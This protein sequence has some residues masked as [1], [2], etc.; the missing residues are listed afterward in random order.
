MMK[1]VLCVEKYWEFVRTLRN[2]ERV[3]DGFIE[4]INIT[5]E[6]QKVYM[7]KYSEYYRIALVNDIPAGYVGVIEDDIRICTH[8]DYQNMGVGK[9]MLAEILKEFPTAYG[10]VKID[11]EASKKLF[12]SLGFKESFIIFTK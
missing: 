8:P 3:S 11:N 2:D 12:K 7:S 9:Y 4:M 5:P 10:K 6:M 1:L